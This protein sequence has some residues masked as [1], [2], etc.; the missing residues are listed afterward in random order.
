MKAVSIA[1]GLAASVVVV[2]GACNGHSPT[3]PGD[4]APTVYSLSGLVTEPIG[5][6]LAGVSVTVTDGPAKGKSSATDGNGRYVLVGVEGGFTVDISKEG[7][8]TASKPVTVP[9]ML[10]LDVELTPLVPRINISGKWAVTFEP[11]CQDF[12]AEDVKRYSA[13]IVQQGA[14]LEVALSGATFVTPPQLTGTI[15]FRNISIVLPDGS[16]GWYC[17]YYAPTEP[18]GIVERIAANQF[19]VISGVITATAGQSSLTGNLDGQ[20]TI[21]RTATQPFDVVAT[22]TKRH[23]VTF[24]K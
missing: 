8:A 14:A 1:F 24:T 3:S 4:L 2:A 7:Y 18:P 23:Q 17:Y 12:L 5:V 21:T 11:G 22:C 20:M 15:D 10:E 9:Q 13:S 16:C 6:P 19:L